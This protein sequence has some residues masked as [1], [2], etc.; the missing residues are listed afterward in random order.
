M[1]PRLGGPTR[2]PKA[3]RPNPRPC[4]GEDTSRDLPEGVRQA[5]SQAAPDQE[6][7][8]LVLGTIP[9]LIGSAWYLI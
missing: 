3:A 1:R 9:Q 2:P 7:S 5:L 8:A 6:I 4:G